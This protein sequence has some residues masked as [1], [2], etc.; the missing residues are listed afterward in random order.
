MPDYE[1]TIK[2][3]DEGSLSARAA[4]EHAYTH[5]ITEMLYGALTVE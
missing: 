3:D 5:L 2:Y 1:V 4:A